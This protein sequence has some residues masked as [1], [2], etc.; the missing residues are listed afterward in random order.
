[1]SNKKNIDRLFQEKFRD[2]EVTPS[3]ALWERINNDLPNKKNKR[4]IIALWWK[5]SGVAAVIALLLTIGISV[6]NNNDN[7]KGLPIVNTEDSK[8]TNDKTDKKDNKSIVVNPEKQQ[9]ELTTDNT[10]K[11]TEIKSTIDSNLKKEDD[12]TTIQKNKASNE[13][14]TTNNNS[15]LKQKAI[16]NH[17]TKSESQTQLSSQK[18]NNLI[19]TNK[20]SINK[21]VEETKSSENSSKNLEKNI[22][23]NDSEIKS[24]IR[25]AITNNETTVVDNSTSETKSQSNA[26]NITNGSETEKN[27]ENSTTEIISNQ[28]ESID[29]AIAE[30]T[31]D[32]KEKDEEGNL[33]RWS[34]TPN[35]A[36][37]YFGSLGKDGSPIHSQ[38]NSNSK[39]S[40]ISMSY[41]IAGTYAVSKKLKIR[42]GINRVNLN[43]TTSDIYAFNTALDAS[44]SYTTTNAMVEDEVAQMSNINFN[45]SAPMSLMSSN[46]M[47][48]TSSP[49]V[50]NTKI[51]GDINQRIGFI[52]VPVEL[53]YSLLD[54]K[55]GINL[56]GGFSTL[57]LNTNELYVDIGG[58]STLI[59]EA[60]NINSTSFSANFGLGLDYNLSKQW[61]IN[62]EPTFKYQIN[63]FN[64]T[65]G[66]FRPFFIG[67]YTGLNFKF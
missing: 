34:I 11:V 7:A 35:V 60:S 67:V 3:D 36:P 5:I 51:S 13:L 50:F 31:K 63:T 12:N 53:E 18:N 17:S 62:L 39:S 25:K 33:S 10:I 61:N 29:N 30:N 28:K 66:N 55:F 48:R 54:K 64:N 45:D 52:E 42:A 32:E 59:G 2:F 56:I 15:Q 23:K 38:F 24:V 6:F 8:K 57:F 58:N 49:E 19:N 43:H 47:Q 16:V 21:V 40:D 37:V 22:I 46:I 65:S 27:I 9:N 26:S 41:G 1:M 4:R 20:N 14:T 44:A